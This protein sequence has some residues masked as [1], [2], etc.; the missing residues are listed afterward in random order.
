VTTRQRKGKNRAP[1]VTISTR[2]CYNAG[3]S[4]ISSRIIK[5]EIVYRRANFEVG[6]FLGTTLRG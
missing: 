5:I 6:R 2:D 1:R 4:E 3:Y